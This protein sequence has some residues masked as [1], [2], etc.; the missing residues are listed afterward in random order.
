MQRGGPPSLFDR[1]L[2]MRVGAAAA[3]AVQRGDFGKMMAVRGTEVVAVSLK[4]ATGS[5]K[6]VTD[7][8]MQFAE[9]FWK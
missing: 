4:E 5:L 3:D 1:I 6:L 8:W 7:K 9:V 2:G